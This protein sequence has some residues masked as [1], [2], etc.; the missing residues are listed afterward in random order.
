MSI[1]ALFI[2]AHPGEIERY[3]GGFAALLRKHDHN[4][5][6]L[7]A[8]DGSKSHFEDRYILDS[9]LLARRRYR[10]SV[11]SAKSI[12]AAFHSLGIPEE[13]LYITPANSEEMVRMIRSAGTEGRGPDIIITARPFQGHRDQRYMCQM[14]LDAMFMLQIAAV[15]PDIPR[16]HRLPA[17]LYWKDEFTEP[18]TFIPHFIVPIDDVLTKKASLMDCHQSTYFEWL[19]WIEQQN[20]RM[21]ANNDGGGCTSIERCKR[22]NSLHHFQNSKTISDY[23]EFY[24]IS[25]YGSAVSGEEILSLDVS[26]KIMETF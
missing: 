26:A 17:L 16:L 14:V 5:I 2:E 12:G 13:E 19:P 11:E 6:F 20:N 23:G 21:H 8:T 10:E 3:A 1:T 4:V 7:C 9:D 24:Q 18:S 15:C 25:S 22:E